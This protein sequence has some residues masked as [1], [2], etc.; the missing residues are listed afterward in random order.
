MIRK[1]AGLVLPLLSLSLGLFL[2]SCANDGTMKCPFTKEAPFVPSAVP[3]DF[4]VVVDE[5]HDTFY[6]RQHIQQVISTADMMSRTTYTTFRDLN[7]VVSNRFTQETPLSA[8]QLQNMWNET[9]RYHLLQGARTWINWY[10][11]AD[12][13]K[14]DTYTIQIRANGLTR[15]YRQ[16][17]GFSGVLRPLM[18]QVDAVRLPISQDSKTPIV[19]A[20]PAPATESTPAP[21]TAPAAPAMLPATTPAV[22]DM[23]PVPTTAPQ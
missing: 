23:T 13:Y 16:T 9:A 6:A 12:I 7:N 19:G 10:S 2:A 22:P 5:N 11:D 14:K 15:T 4:A 20:T 18:L 21:A 8:V 3:G 17:N 1:V